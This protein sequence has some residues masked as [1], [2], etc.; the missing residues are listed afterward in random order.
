VSHTRRTKARKKQKASKR[1]SEPCPA[2]VAGHIALGVAT[3]AS[4]LHA[5]RATNVDPMT[6]LRYE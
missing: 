4:W 6:T 1:E 2:F 5:R 3:L